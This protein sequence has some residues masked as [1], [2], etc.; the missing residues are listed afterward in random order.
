M[1][2]KI[3]RNG[4]SFNIDVEGYERFWD[5]FENETWELDTTAI[6]DKYID[7]NTTYLD[8]GAWIGPTLFYV[9][10]L[11]GK[12]F[13]VEA[14]PIAF[15]RL[16]ENLKLNSS[17]D[18]FSNVELINKAIS[19]KAG[20]INFGSQGQGGDSMSSI[21]WG[22]FDTS[23]QVPTINAHQLIEQI[24]DGSNRFFVKIDIEGGEFTM[25]SSLK[26]FFELE[27]ATIYLSLHNI[28][29]KRSLKLKYKHLNFIKRFFKIRS[30]FAATYRELF[31]CLPNNKVCWMNGQKLDQSSWVFFNIWLFC[32][33]P[34]EKKY[35]DILMVP[36]KQ[37]ALQACRY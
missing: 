17:E 22:D 18:W 15:K 13:A 29:L 8:I 19:D 2:K 9:A 31:N 28:Y 3:I 30:E 36:K 25:L 1:M 24:K 5:R 33:P 35:R 23:W 34:K 37:P 12:C 21:L 14:D 6:F 7:K 26:N 32:K 16:D 11:A 10:E 27:N 4:H 20:V